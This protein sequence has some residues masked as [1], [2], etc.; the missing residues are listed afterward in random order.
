[1]SYTCCVP[2]CHGYYP[3]GP[4]VNIFGFPLSEE[5]DKNEFTP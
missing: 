4:K 2:N 5:L 3:N 1:M